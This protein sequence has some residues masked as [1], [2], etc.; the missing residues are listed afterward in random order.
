MSGLPIAF[1]EHH[2]MALYMAP[3]SGTQLGQ[4]FLCNTLEIN[5]AYCDYPSLIAHMEVCTSI[6]QTQAL[7]K[8]E[9]YMKMP[10]SLLDLTQH[11]ALWGRASVASSHSSRSHMPQGHADSQLT[12]VSTGALT[13]YQ[14]QQP[15]NN[16]Q[17]MQMC[18][19]PCS[20]GRRKESDAFRMASG[21]DSYWQCWH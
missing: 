4:I 3:A 13:C 5:V 18:Q 10:G 1:T 21:G 15:E 12:T 9:P 20:E 16:W 11:R 7:M 14:D 19:L 6:W 8:P 17:M 2:Y